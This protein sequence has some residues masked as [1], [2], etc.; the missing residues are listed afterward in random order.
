MLDPFTGLFAKK[1]I[2]QGGSSD[3]AGCQVRTMSC[4]FD[5]SV[6]YESSQQFIASLRQL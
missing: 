1:K 5:D 4:S 3:M 2:I 6:S